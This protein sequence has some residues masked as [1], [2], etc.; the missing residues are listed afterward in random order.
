MNG[1]EKFCKNVKRKKEES[2][3]SGTFGSCTIVVQ[4]HVL[5]IVDVVRHINGGVRV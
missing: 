1:V 2:T 5:S 4:I 3:S